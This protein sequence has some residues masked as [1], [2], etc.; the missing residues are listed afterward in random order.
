MGFGA[1]AVQQ[2][3]WNAPRLRESLWASSTRCPA[4]VR[5]HRLRRMSWVSSTCRRSLSW[6]SWVLPE[7]QKKEY[8]L[9]WNWGNRI[10]TNLCSLHGSLRVFFGALPPF[11]L[12][13]LWSRLGWPVSAERFVPSSCPRHSTQG[14]QTSQHP[15]W[16][17]WWQDRVRRLWVGKFPQ[18]W[19]SNLS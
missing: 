7:G 19:H 12:H 3:P 9:N 10:S 15:G 11:S 13:Q 1:E 17:W 5:N 2:W 6:R 8:C 14:C 16:P 18:S 4:K